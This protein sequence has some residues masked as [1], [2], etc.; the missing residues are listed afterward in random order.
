[1]KNYIVALASFNAKDFPEIIEYIFTL[2]TIKDIKI[3]SFIGIY[4]DEGV[5]YNVLNSLLDITGKSSPE[6]RRRT[7]QYN[8]Y[9]IM[10]IDDGNDY[11]KLGTLVVCKTTKV[12][13]KMSNNYDLDIVSCD[14]E[15]IPIETYGEEFTKDDIENSV[16]TILSNKV[17]E[18]KSLTTY[19]FWNHDRNV[20]LAVGHVYNSK[21][22]YTESSFD[23]YIKK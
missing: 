16:Y 10:I 14:P 6:F 8:N 9:P 23:K 21:N 3:T 12:T 4:N 17:K 19:I 11:I 7:S 13:M 5:A 15:W 18:Q 22:N 2:D 1:M 20:R